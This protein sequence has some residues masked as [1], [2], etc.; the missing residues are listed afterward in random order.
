MNSNDYGVKNF[1]HKVSFKNIVVFSNQEKKQTFD[2]QLPL[3]E[4]RY[5]NVV[6]VEGSEAWKVNFYDALSGEYGDL[7]LEQNPN[8]KVGHISQFIYDEA[9]INSPDFLISNGA[10][11]Y[12]IDGKFYI[13][14]DGVTELEEV[15]ITAQ[16]KPFEGSRKQNRIAKRLEDANAFVTVF[17][18]SDGAQL[19]RAYLNINQL[20]DREVVLFIETDDSSNIFGSVFR[21]KSGDA[22]DS[23]TFLPTRKMAR[24]ARTF[25]NSVD[26]GYVS[27]IIKK[28]LKDKG[29]ENENS[30][31][32]ILNRGL[33]H[34][35]TRLVEIAADFTLAPL[36]NF[37][38][39]VSIG[40][41][42]NL[43]LSDDRWEATKDGKPNPDY[44]PILPGY[45]LIT[46]SFSPEKL[47]KTIDEEFFKPFTPKI[48]DIVTKLKSV[49]PLDKLLGNRLNSVEQ[50]IDKIPEYLTKL[51]KLIQSALKGAFEFYNGLLVGIINSL[52]DLLKT[53]FDILALICKG[54]HALLKE[55]VKF[56][57]S[58]GAYM[59]MII[60]GLENGIEIITNAITLDNLKAFMGFQFFIIKKVGELGITAIQSLQNLSLSDVK[61][62]ASEAT[63]ISIPFDSIGYYTGYIIGFIAQEVLIF[64]ATAG[65]G[66]VAEGIRG[67]VRSYVELGKAIGRVS[68]KIA[69]GVHRKITISVE[70]FLRIMRSIKS[71]VKNIPKHFE[72]LKTWVDNLI[73]G[74]LNKGN[75]LFQEF[76]EAIKLL[77]SLGVTII[78]NID[79]NLSPALVAQGADGT[80]YAVKQGSTSIFNGT[81]SQ[82]DDFLRKIEDIRN[83][84]GNVTKKVQ[85][86][87]D[88]LAGSFNLKVKRNS[89]TISLV[90]ENGT[91]VF[92]A[93][94]D[95]DLDKYLKFIGKNVEERRALIKSMKDRLKSSDKVYKQENALAKGYDIPTSKN[96]TSPDFDGL[97]D[98]LYKGNPDFGRVKIKVT[99]SRDRDFALANKLMDLKET[100]KGYTWHHLDDLDE[101]L[102]CTM[103]LI[104][105]KA[106]LKTYNH[107]GSAKQLQ[108]LLNIKDYL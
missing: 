3:S 95:L 85:K 1:D 83:S 42:D 14:L 8:A 12:N 4:N 48:K 6:Q 69:K 52:V 93:I 13:I 26:T 35:G 18:S 80:L 73:T 33:L 105:T 50:F 51:L 34:L 72:T 76:I 62:A 88:E 29:T 19:E 102:G 5:V 41:N 15:V 70:F 17:I 61:E 104:K 7:Y 92:K 78:K 82:I 66:T 98:Y 59:G 44:K 39:Y 60:E 2:E 37:F 107:I 71:F 94:D 103:Q 53:V 97:T 74:F 91:I 108:E 23:T 75:R 89:K 99:G 57:N 67:A 55:G 46:E 28:H 49:K 65:V 38:E 10:D 25:G 58:P 9:I 96:G 11:Y 63:D 16:G 40:I 87:I 21:V 27:Q 47:A 20:M 86:Y 64:M 77:E 24:I 56:V 68:S 32:L 79:S 22:I 54:L 106:H 81:K 84:G 31:F 101:G 30:F 43:R 45:K 36:G 100:P 90:D